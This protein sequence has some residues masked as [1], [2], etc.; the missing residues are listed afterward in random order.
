MEHH[1]VEREGKNALFYM[2][3]I[4]PDT[5]RRMPEMNC[6]TLNPLNNRIRNHKDQRG[7]DLDPVHLFEI[8]LNPAHGHPA[9]C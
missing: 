8:D 3:M 9:Q 5:Q 1:G 6:Q 2:P 4:L 7:R